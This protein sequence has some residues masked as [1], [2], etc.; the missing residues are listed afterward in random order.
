MQQGN[1]VPLA[2][3]LERAPVCAGSRDASKV[4]GKFDARSSEGGNLAR[5]I[6]DEARYTSLDQPSCDPVALAQI[7]AA[8]AATLRSTQYLDDRIRVIYHGCLEKFMGFLDALHNLQQ[9]NVRGDLAEKIASELGTRKWH[10]HGRRF[11]REA[12]SFIAFETGSSSIANNRMKEF[13]FTKEESDILKSLFH[14]EQILGRDIHGE[15]AMPRTERF[16]AATVTRLCIH[17]YLE[18]CDDCLALLPIWA[19]LLGIRVCVTHSKSHARERNYSPINK[20]ERLPVG[21][22]FYGDPI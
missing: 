13:W 11:E 20:A 18:P 6:I 21:V 7:A 3:Q 15:L 8:V 2:R 22:V 9:Y 1:V 5:L 10:L 14:S 16:A 12:K 19:H 17:T 4:K